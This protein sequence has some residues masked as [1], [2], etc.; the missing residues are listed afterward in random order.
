MAQDNEN[1][2]LGQLFLDWLASRTGEV[3]TDGETSD[4]G[5]LTAALREIPLR[6]LLAPASSQEPSPEW[7]STLSSF[8]ARLNPGGTGVLVWLPAGAEPPDA[9]PLASVTANLL[10]RTIDS[11]GAGESV[12]AR[13]PIEI[14]IRKRDDAGAYVSAFGGLSPFWAQF[15]DRV[16]GYYHVDSRQLHRLPDDEEYIKALVDSVVAASK[17]LAVGDSAVVLAEDSWR[18]QRLRSGHSCAIIGLPPGDESET[19]T[20]LRK[21]LRAAVRAAGDQFE[22]EPGA[23]R[24]LAVCGH[25]SSL[26]SDPVGPSLRGQ[27]PSLFKNLDMVVLIADGGVKPLIDITRQTALQARKRE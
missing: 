17:G 8:C 23:L 22:A 2:L 16:D 24:L 7:T 19:G 9:E 6:A 5:L 15:T 20:P 25:Y 26:E 21:R 4:D 14:T 11:L 27:D 3:L 10:Q 18:V 1:R 12:D 13:L